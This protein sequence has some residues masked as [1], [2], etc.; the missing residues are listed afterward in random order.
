MT[1]ASL[2]FPAASFDAVVCQQAFQFFA[3]PVAAA[4][5]IGRVVKKGGRLAVSVCRP[6]RF[7]P[8]YVALADLLHRH[9]GSDAGAMMRSPFAPWTT[10]EFRALFTAAGW[11]SVRATIEVWPLR[12]PSSDEFLRQEASSSPLAGPIGALEPERRDA[13]RRD[14][15]AAVADQVDDD[16][17]ACPIQVYV[18]VARR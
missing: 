13:L 9:V 4:R 14:L 15:A 12:Y 8:T 11:T 7:A 1:S 17:V 6:I 5:E 2:P 10:A 18:G 3:D 16:G